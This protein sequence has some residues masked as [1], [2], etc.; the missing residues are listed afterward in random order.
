MTKH[1]STGPAIATGLCATVLVLAACSQQASNSG[2]APASSASAPAVSSTAPASSSTASAQQAYTPPTADQLYQLV[3]PIALFPD[4][5]V[6]QVLAGST[7]PDQITSAQNLVTQNPN[8][9]GDLLQ[10]AVQPQGWDP[11]V[12]GLTQFPSVLGQMAQNIQ[13][14]TAL[15]QAYVNDP[16]DVLNAIQVMRQRASAQ[17][18]LRSSAQQQVVTQPAQ[19]V[20]QS[21]DQSGYVQSGSAP[22]VYSGPDVV[23]PPGQIIQIEPAQPDAVYVPSYDPQTV[24]GG[25]VP[26]YPSYQYVQPGYSTGE[27][28]A[29]G[30]VAFGAAI[31]IGSLLDSHHGGWHSWGMN[32]GG[33]GGYNS[34]GPGGGWHHPAV[35]YN[36]QT[37]VSRS[38]TVVNRYTTINNVT[39]NRYNTVN[40]S[41]VTNNHT[42]NNGATSNVPNSVANN[43]D[44]FNR[45]VPNN[46][47]NNAATHPHPAGRPMSVPNF[48]HAGYPPATAAQPV[49]SAQA[50]HPTEAPRP[51]IVRQPANAAASAHAAAAERAQQAT[52]HLQPA[53]AHPAPQATHQTPQPQRTQPAFH[54][55]PAAQQAHPQSP[56]SQPPHPAV[57]PAPRPQPPAQ[58]AAPP[59]PQPQPQAHP[60]PQPQHQ[61]NGNAHQSAPK[62]KDDNQH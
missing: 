10:A 20:V 29:V 45:N 25:E 50:P 37:Y 56:H 14:T 57:A 23:P 7:Y 48:G 11:S 43:R 2:A 47:A 35:V 60:A 5:L 54:P 62:K 21:E 18:N 61:N 36:N 3:A 4:K 24:Y 12:K 49:R 9:K 13:W 42:F 55:A 34:G 33:G 17:G 39:N 31:V 30:A 15:G 58:H 28:V 1:Y 8:L 26:Y 22:P 6:A 16:T 46:L 27:V 40:N 59:R 41:T 53:A 19:Q 38:T 52:P 51:N 32:W 44:Q